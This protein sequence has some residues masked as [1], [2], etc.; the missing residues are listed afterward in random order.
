MKKLV[1]ACAV[2]AASIVILI[3]FFMPW[4]GVSTSAIRISKQMT[5]DTMDDLKDAPI[6]SHLLTG[7]KE[8]ANIIGGLGDVEMNMVVTGYDIP[9]EANKKLSKVAISL[10]QTLLRDARN[11]HKKSKLIYLMPVFAVGCIIFALVGTRYKA[12]IALMSILSGVLSM[13]GLYNL[14]TANLSSEVL[15]I[16]I[17]R[18]LW[19]TLYAYLFIFIVSIVWFG[20][21]I[22]KDR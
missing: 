17:G 16:T 3:S 13:G 15:E 6:S 5:S 10:L 19:M 20:L 8:A 22:K 9:V 21:G 18:G 14:K 12:A 11:L 7:F 1:P 4:A 2:I